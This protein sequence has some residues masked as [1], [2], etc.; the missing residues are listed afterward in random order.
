MT[1]STT[2]TGTEC[3]ARNSETVRVVSASPS[4]PI[5]TAST[6]TSSNTESNCARKNDWGGVWISRTPC[7]FWATS[8]VTTHM[9]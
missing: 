7:V 2:T 4:M 5:F 3:W 1:G 9:P 6:V 8:A